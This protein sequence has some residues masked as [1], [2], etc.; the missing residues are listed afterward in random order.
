[1]DNPLTKVIIEPGETCGICLEELADV[2][3]VIKLKCSHI[4]CYDCILDSYSTHHKSHQKKKQRE[5][6]YCRKNGGYLPLPENTAP[7]KNIH[8]EYVIHNLPSL[9]LYYG[10]S[11]YKKAVLVAIAK[12]LSISITKPNMKKKLKKDLYDDIKNLYTSNSSILDSY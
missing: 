5:C 8:E 3:N 11:H 7:L 12:K 4:Y 2:D 10:I 1:M 6:P 9:P